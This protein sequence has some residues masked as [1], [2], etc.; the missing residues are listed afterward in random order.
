MDNFT[1]MIYFFLVLF[2]ILFIVFYVLNLIKVKRKKYDSL[3]EINDVIKRFKI[4]K[5]KVNYRQEIKYVALINSFIIASVGTFITYLDIGIVF[6][7][8]IGFILL[9]ALIYA[10]YEIYGRF[11][12]KKV[13]R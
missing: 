13:G 9:L 5:S 7:L 6:Q 3:K 11:L 2:I 4:D 10:L 12:K 1:F 8:G